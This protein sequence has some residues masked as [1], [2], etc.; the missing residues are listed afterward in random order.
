MGQ[1]YGRLFVF[2]L[3][4]LGRDVI[5]TFLGAILARIHGNCSFCHYPGALRNTNCRLSHVSHLGSLKTLIAH[6][7]L[8]KKKQD[9]FRLMCIRMHASDSISS[10]SYIL[11]I[12]PKYGVMFPSTRQT[13]RKNES[14]GTETIHGNR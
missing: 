10:I 4:M 2:L 7:T 8:A 6:L 1:S 5:L 3:G 12:L 14:K 9:L 13:N 11:N